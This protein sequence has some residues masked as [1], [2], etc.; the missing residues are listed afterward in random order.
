MYQE[1]DQH[2]DQELQKCKDIACHKG[3]DA[4]CK[5]AS[6]IPLVTTEATVILAYIKEKARTAQGQKILQQM[7][8]YTGMDDQCPFLVDSECGIYAVRPLACRTFYIHGEP[9][10][11]DEVEDGSRIADM[12]LWDR[13]KMAPIHR[14][15]IEKLY[16]YKHPQ[17]QDQAFHDGKIAEK[18]FPLGGFAWSTLGGGIER[19][20]VVTDK[21]DP[22]S[23]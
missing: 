19:M 17:E 20:T 8:S 2:M 3:C 11:E 12:H 7:K 5:K 22:D 15:L 13:D 6:S 23:K 10:T 16:G 4:C 18:T 9:C 14:P 21:S 1:L